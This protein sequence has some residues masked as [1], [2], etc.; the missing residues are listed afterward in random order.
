MSMNSASDNMIY[1]IDVLS[2][3]SHDYRD[4]I[5]QIVCQNQHVV[6][7]FTH[8]IVHTSRIYD[9]AI[10]TN[11]NRTHSSPHLDDTVRNWYQEFVYAINDY[12]IKLKTI[13]EDFRFILED[14]KATRIVQEEVSRKTSTFAGRMEKID[15]KETMDCVVKMMDG[16]KRIDCNDH[17]DLNIDPHPYNRMRCLQKKDICNVYRTDYGYIKPRVKNPSFFHDSD[18]DAAKKMILSLRCELEEKDKEISEY[19]NEVNK[20][21]SELVEGMKKENDYKRQQSNNNSDRP[22]NHH[23]D[24]SNKSHYEAQDHQMRTLMAQ[25]DQLNTKVKQY[26]DNEESLQK[27]IE[28]LQK[29]VNQQSDHI[30]NL[31]LTPLYARGGEEDDGYYTHDSMRQLNDER[32]KNSRVMMEEEIEKTR[33]EMQERISQI[34]AKN[35]EEMALLKN[36]MMNFS[37][38]AG[39]GGKSAEEV[40]KQRYELER[41]IEVLKKNHQI[42]IMEERAEKDKKIGELVKDVEMRQKEI[43]QV[44]NSKMLEIKVAE[45]MAE[46]KIQEQLTLERIENERR[47]R[48]FEE[49]MAQFKSHIERLEGENGLLGIEVESQKKKVE[50]MKMLKEKEEDNSTKNDQLLICS[51][52]KLIE[53]MKSSDLGMEKIKGLPQYSLPGLSSQVSNLSGNEPLED[54]IELASGILQEKNAFIMKNHESKLEEKEKLEKMMDSLGQEYQLKENKLK[55]DINSYK[56]EIQDILSKKKEND[57]HLERKTSE[58][59]KRCSDLEREIERLKINTG[60][61]SKSLSDQEE[62]VIQM[63]KQQEHF[64]KEK[65]ELERSMEDLKKTSLAKEQDILKKSNETEIKLNEKIEEASKQLENMTRLN[66]DIEEKKN[67]NQNQLEQIAKQLKEKTKQIQSSVLNRI[68]DKNQ[69]DNKIKEKDEEIRKLSEMTDNEKESNKIK[70][71]KI[72]SMEKDK[73][74]MIEKIAEMEKFI[75]KSK[76]KMIEYMKNNKFEEDNNE[77]NND[78]SNIENW[79]EVLI[80]K[81]KKYENEILKQNEDLRKE[82]ESKENLSSEKDREL[83]E[84]LKK[85]EEVERKLEDSIREREGNVK[86][87]EVKL[88]ETISNLQAESER[89]LEM[90]KIEA[91]DKMKKTMEILEREKEELAKNQV[92]NAVEEVKNAYEKEIKEVKDRL[93]EDLRKERESKEN[94]SS[95]KDRELGEALKKKEEVERKLEDSIREREGNVKEAE[96]KLQETI[97]NLQAESERKLELAKIASSHHLQEVKALLDENLATLQ[98]QSKISLE[99]LNLDLKDAQGELSNKEDKISKL[100]NDIEDLKLQLSSQNSNI[101][102]LTTQL[103]QSNNKI[104]SQNDKLK[105]QDSANLKLIKTLEDKFAN[106]Q[107]TIDQLKKQHQ[108]ERDRYQRITEELS[109]E[110]DIHRNH[111]SDRIEEIKSLRDQRENELI[112]FSQGISEFNRNLEDERQDFNRKLEMLDNEKKNQMELLTSKIHELMEIQANERKN[113]D[114]QVSLENENKYKLQEEYNKKSGLMKVLVDEYK[115]QLEN[116]KQENMELK[117]V[118]EETK[119]SIID[120]VNKVE[121]EEDSMVGDEDMDEVPLNQALEG[122]MSIAK[123]PGKKFNF[124]GRNLKE[125]SRPLIKLPRAQSSYGDDPYGNTLSPSFTPK[126]QRVKS[127]RTNLSTSMNIVLSTPAP[128]IME[129][130]IIPATVVVPQGPQKKE[131]EPSLKKKIVNFVLGRSINPIQR[132]ARQYKQKAGELT[133][134]QTAR[135]RIRSSPHSDWIDL[136]KGGCSVFSVHQFGYVVFGGEWAASGKLSPEGEVEESGRR[137]EGREG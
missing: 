38:K 32:M 73:C 5:L 79:I 7:E 3:L 72:I 82:R 57:D 55:D 88:Q 83:G 109:K 87:A 135:E 52:K 117:S 93:E 134:A 119:N 60:E 40:E 105:D 15:L 129:L 128:P 34:E 37:K 68:S 90:A 24:V 53:M 43:E 16:M 44:Q 125:A 71:L 6:K 29:T 112:S 9:S 51:K 11:N 45:L 1:T 49:K 17:C 114:L 108:E 101:D 99:Q 80:K 127:S 110:L 115:K 118:Y 10:L 36:E 28:V 63:L 33:H 84:A 91:E 137:E 58:N 4:M 81:Q 97:S 26:Q 30:N 111:I 89:K 47:T 2:R 132:A 104:A 59:Q 69:F 27:E 123:S 121:G 131:I 21:M 35:A 136:G 102:D 120:F 133:S 76:D 20:K 77:K 48:D 78:I 66:K 23:T 98:N 54:L 107:K 96:V 124:S 130:Y 13:L 42:E 95:E 18:T 126:I 122:L 64:Q 41:D 106:S 65:V 8:H 103:S 19:K 94:L 75:N 61:L 67:D 39:L 25:I 92:S 46:K 70:E 22:T 74:K 86:E 116:M 56:S 113:H 12:R 31:Q 85:K 50:E 62:K 14:L 100:M